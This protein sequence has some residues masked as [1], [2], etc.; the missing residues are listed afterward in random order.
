MRVYMYVYLLS[1]V[2]FGT[3]WAND[4]Y[5]HMAANAS[6]V[7]RSNKRHL[8][9]PRPEISSSK[10]PAANCLQEIEATHSI[11]KIFE[12]KRTLGGGVAELPPTRL[13][14]DLNAS[15]AGLPVPAGGKDNHRIP[16]T[17]SW[18]SVRSE[19]R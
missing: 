9:M 16:M 11:F 8:V 17:S 10:L 13:I 18:L 12:A 1:Q 2:K 19:M 6:H 7:T 5:V 14:N 3:Q 15:M 4:T